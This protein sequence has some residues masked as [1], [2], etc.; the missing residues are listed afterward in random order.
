MYQAHPEGGKSWG[1][2]EPIISN[3]GPNVRTHKR[4]F[5]QQSEYSICTQKQKNR[6]LFMPHQHYFE[7]NKGNQDLLWKF[8]IPTREREKVLKRLDQHNLNAFTLFGSEDS[9]METLA[10]RQ[11]IF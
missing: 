6:Y 11:I 5:I 1:I 8:N 10:L 7:T 4:H 9:L 3:L 2:D